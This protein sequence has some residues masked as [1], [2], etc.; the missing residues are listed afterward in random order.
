MYKRQLWAVADG[1]ATFYDADAVFE[2]AAEAHADRAVDAAAPDDA[3]SSSDDGAPVDYDA[4]DT[5]MDIEKMIA[6]A[7]RK[8]EIFLKTIPE[9][10]AKDPHEHIKD[11]MGGGENLFF[12]VPH[13][14]VVG[15]PARIYVNKSR[16]ETLRGKHN[17]RFIAGFNDWKLNEWDTAMIP[18]GS[19][20]DDYCFSEFEVPDLA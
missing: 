9:Q 15:N 4:V 12:T 5:T 11:M 10:V 7:K 20:A 17:V 14:L 2:A 8:E 3:S 18:V 1:A 13:K 6:D 16:S 19:D